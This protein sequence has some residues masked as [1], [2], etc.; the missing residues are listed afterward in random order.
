MAG[1]AQPYHCSLHNVSHPL[2][3]LWP[4]SAILCLI[5][6]SSSFAAVILVRADQVASDLLLLTLTHIDQAVQEL[7]VRFLSRYCLRSIASPVQYDPAYRL[8]YSMALLYMVRFS[9]I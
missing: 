3:I 1:I 9:F 2:P 4:A 6:S 5:C 7:C 8:S